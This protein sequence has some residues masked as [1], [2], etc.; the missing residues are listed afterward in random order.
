MTSVELVEWLHQNIPS[1]KSLQQSNN[2]QIVALPTYI[3]EGVRGLP[4]FTLYILSS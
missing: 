2:S 3:P 4:R 1:S